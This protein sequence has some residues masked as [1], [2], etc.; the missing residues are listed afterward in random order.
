MRSWQQILGEMLCLLS[1]PHNH[2]RENI[3]EGRCDRLF[4]RVELAFGM[5]IEIALGTRADA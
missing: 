2:A 3:S 5:S 4:D 1:A